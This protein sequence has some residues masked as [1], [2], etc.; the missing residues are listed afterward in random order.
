VIGLIAFGGFAELHLEISEVR[1]L[2][3]RVLASGWM[4][5]RGT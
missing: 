1:D 5:G 2:G 4:R 3:N